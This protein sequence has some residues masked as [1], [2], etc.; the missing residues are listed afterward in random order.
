MDPA[1]IDRK[2]RETR[3]EKCREFL[4]VLEGL[5]RKNFRNLVTGNESWFTLEFQHSAK[6]SV[7]R[8]DMPQKVR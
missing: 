2:L 1:C 6:W 4:P 7:S 3:L 5:E 8:D